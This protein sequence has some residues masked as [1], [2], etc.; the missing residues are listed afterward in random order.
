MKI[1][2][3]VIAGFLFLTLLIAIQFLYWLNPVTFVDIIHYKDQLIFLIRNQPMLFGLIYASLYALSIVAGI[4]ISATIGGGYLFGIGKG[5]LY[6]LIG[7]IVGTITLC[8]LVRYIFKDWVQQQYKKMLKPFNKEL[9]Q[10]GMHYIIMTHMIPFMP[11]FLPHI[12][13][14]IT[15]IPFWQLISMNIVGALPLTLVY[16]VAGSYI[17]S[18]HSLKELMFFIVLIS[19]LLAALYIFVLMYRRM[20]K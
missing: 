10:Y 12:A 8:A 2:W 1:A 5:L 17:H 19:G 3:R 6:T 7:L 13:M 20:L 14:S 11:S 4:P 16:T 9:K 18:L 15:S